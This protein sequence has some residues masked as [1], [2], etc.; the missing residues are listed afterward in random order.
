MWLGT[1]IIF[2]L[3]EYMKLVL[4]FGKKSFPFNHFP[5]NQSL[6]IK[7]DKL[8]FPKSSPLFC[9][10]VFESCSLYW[11]NRFGALVW[12]EN[13]SS[14]P[15]SLYLKFIYQIRQTWILLIIFILFVIGH[16]NQALLTVMHDID[17]LVSQEKL[18]LLPFLD[19]D[20][21]VS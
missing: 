21:L 14:P 13:L 20:A 9:D 1:T 15:F 17:A 11:D 3:L 4:W 2:S 12:Q 16:H 8:G 19:I 7:W 6:F 5:Y 10:W 18:F